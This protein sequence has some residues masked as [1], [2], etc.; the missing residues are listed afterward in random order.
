MY[1]LRNIAL[2]GAL[3]LASSAHAQLT[4]TPDPLQYVVAPETP[5]PNE[6]VT[7]QAQGVGGFLGDATI[8]WTQD[9]KV[10]L[11]GVGESQYSF[12]TGALGTQNRVSVRIVSQSHGTFTRD[13][14]FVPSVVHL[15]WEADTSAPPLYRGK[16]LYSAGSNLKVVAYPTVLSSSGRIPNSSLSMQWSYNGEKVTSQSG[17]GKTIFAFT[18]S[19]I[20]NAERVSLDVLLNGTKVAH[21]EVT[22]PATNPLL[23]LYAKDSLRGTVYDAALPSAVV[24]NSKEITLEATPYYFANSSL[25]NGSLVYSWTLNGEDMSGP[26]SAQGLLTLRQS[27]AGAG[28]ATVGV[29]LQNTE[30]DR[31]VQAARAALQIVFGQQ[32]SGSLFGL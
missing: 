9:G 4:V 1:K 21:G 22:I 28:T 23:L 15:V 30:P 27:G 32:S 26:Q 12:T 25:K 19:Q 16:S 3:L 13:F 14:T 18:G 6:R 29:E 10:A 11:S 17:L 24:L 8:T 5:G 7:I 20:Q 31:F 2:L